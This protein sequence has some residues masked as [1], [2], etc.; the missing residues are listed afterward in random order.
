MLVRDYLC[1]V[2]EKAF[3]TKV[4]KILKYVKDKGHVTYFLERIEV[5]RKVYFRLNM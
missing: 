3:K 5:A 1:K 4:D 2:D